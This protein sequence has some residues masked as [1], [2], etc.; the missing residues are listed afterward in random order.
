MSEK[1][2]CYVDETGQDSEG[3]IFIVSVIIPE[4][5][6]DT[7]SYIRQI[8]IKS[9]K[10]KFK[11]GRAEKTKRLRFMSEI[12]SQKKFP[13]KLFY[14][15]YNE[16]K[17]YKISTI[18]T[19]AKSIVTQDNNDKNTFIILVDG[20]N[21][22]DQRFYNYQ[23]RRLNKSSIK[24]KGVAKDENDALIRLADSLCGFIRDV[25]EKNDNDIQL[26][27][28]FDNAIKQ[29]KITEV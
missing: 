29:D 12:L 19:I 22:T 5:R 4:K 21:K 14:S 6:D 13:L 24:V 18:L 28:L 7:L 11:W 27:E 10:G 3:G 9:G 20:L 26:K 1:I 16:S 2:Y 15:I 23:L 8:E 25:Y 17:D